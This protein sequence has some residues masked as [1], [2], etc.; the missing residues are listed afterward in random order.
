MARLKLFP[1]PNSGPHI[2]LFSTIDR[3]GVL[4]ILLRRRVG[5]CLVGRRGMV[6]GW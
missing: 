5:K 4:P 2:A 3:R 6:G 1:Y